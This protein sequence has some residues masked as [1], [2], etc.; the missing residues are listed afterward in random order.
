[1]E[2]ELVQNESTVT[3]ETVE[4]AMEDVRTAER[5]VLSDGASK[6]LRYIEID[7]RMV[8]DHLCPAYRGSIQTLISDAKKS[9][10][11]KQKS[12]ENK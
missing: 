10:T 11:A 8:T 3:D 4:A 6:V 2:E 12:D 7:P 9:S 5:V 1:M